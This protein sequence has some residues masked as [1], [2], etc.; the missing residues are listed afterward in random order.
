LPAY[1]PEEAALLDDGLSGHLF[2]TAFVTGTPGDDKHFE[3]RVRAA[4]SIWVVKVA[5]ISREG[6]VGKSRG[7]GLVFRPLET[8]LGPPATDL[9]SISVSAK[10][11]SFQW[12]DRGNG[13]WVGTEVVL[14]V[15][16]FR[17]V[18]GSA[19][20][21]HGEPNTPAVRARIDA[22]RATA[23]QTEPAAPAK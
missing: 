1:G 12:L 2:E 15:R 18:D 11:P 4:Q 17:A 9:I 7:Y 22:I 23:R 16:N 10:D 20:H 8:L 19:L 6:S 13:G 14:M 5:T 3:A 21:F